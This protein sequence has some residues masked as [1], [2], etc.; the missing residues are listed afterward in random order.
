MRAIFRIQDPQAA[1]SGALARITLER[2]VAGEGF[3]VPITALAE[4][5]RGL[6]ST[7][8]LAPEP[9]AEER[10]RIDRRQVEVLHTDARRAFV[11]G[12]VQQGDVLVATGLQRLVPGQL[13][14]VTDGYPALAG[15]PPAPVSIP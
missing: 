8:A 5:H 14:R 6:W 15:E 2:E 7:Y 4:S 9:D 13:V 10:F 1:R 3:W 12:A 11:R